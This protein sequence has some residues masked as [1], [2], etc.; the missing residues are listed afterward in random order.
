MPL[1]PVSVSQLNS[2]IKRI[3]ATDPIL[4]NVS[5]KGEIS[6]L[7]KHS[8]GHWY[9]TLKDETS[10]INCFLPADRVFGLR[11]DISEGMELIVY[12]SVSVYERGGS[13]SVYVRDIDVQG[14]G[15]L[16]IAFENL[17]RKLEAEGLF[18]PDV[19]RP[20]PEFPKRIG[21]LTSPTGAAVHDIITT[22]K[23]RN[24]LVDVLIY[25]CIVQGPEAAASIVN[26]LAEMNKLFPDLDVI[27]AGRGGGSAEDLWCFNEESVARAIRASEIPVISAV[28]HE[29]DFTIADFAADLRGATPTAAAELAVPHMAALIDTLQLYTP[30]R[31][32]QNLQTGFENYGL[33]LQRLRDSVENS[34]RSRIREAESRLEL[35][36]ND[37]DLSNPMNVLDKGYAMAK[38]GGEW[39]E[40]AAAFAKGDSLDLRFKDGTLVCLVQEVTIHE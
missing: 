14:E 22:V 39:V 11:F 20:I 21:V 9:F 2:Y 28:G 3:L 33:S 24:P 35:L 12:G 15:S 19:K 26:G 7:T 38:K 27:I 32:Y 8:S 5:V 31:L 13:Y 10:R 23:R 29:V 6:N 16:K 30:Q 1:K 18:D 34:I 25:P 37:A 40:R 4:S 36:K 17:R